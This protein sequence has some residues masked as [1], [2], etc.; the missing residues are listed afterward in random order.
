MER[1]MYECDICNRAYN[2]GSS[3]VTKYFPNNIASCNP[4][5]QKIEDEIQITIKQVDS[6]GGLH[7]RQFDICPQC[8][9][10]LKALIVNAGK[11]I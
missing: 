2:M 10:N 1:K 5:E 11:I 4:I 8:F 9:S 7:K 3:W 6:S